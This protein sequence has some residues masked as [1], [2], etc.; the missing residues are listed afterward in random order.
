LIRFDEMNLF[1]EVLIV[2]ARR[3]RERMKEDQRNKK[4][5]KKEIES[6]DSEENLPD[7]KRDL[8]EQ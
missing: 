3:E 6:T 8:R 7:S 2:S 1:Q 4:E 5:R